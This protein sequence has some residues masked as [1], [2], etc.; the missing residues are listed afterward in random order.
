M[1]DYRP[2]SFKSNSIFDFD[3]SKRKV[4]GYL[5]AFNNKDL[6]NDIILKGAFSKSLQERGVESQTKRKIAFL[7]FHDFTK[8]LG[9]F[10]TLKEDDNGLYFEAEIDPTPMGDET[11]IQ[12]ST[13]TLNQHSIGFQY[14]Y[15][16]M[17]YSVN[18]NANII[19]ELNLWEGSVV[20]IGANENTPFMGFKG[21]TKDFIKD[22]NRLLNS[23]DIETNYEL[24]KYINY[25]LSLKYPLI[26]PAIEPK[27][28]DWE[29]IIY[30]LKKN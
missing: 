1:K 28:I 24:R 6:D 30:E 20:S 7:K 29:R 23:L 15:D 13:G 8:P 4:S 19:K 14:V 17:D 11:L 2:I 12:Y 25:L 26:E 10:T 21:E 9:R 16:K 22:F 18:D 3:A 27:A 5:A